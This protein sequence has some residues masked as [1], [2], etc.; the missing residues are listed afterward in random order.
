[1]EIIENHFEEKQQRKSVVSGA[2]KNTY[3]QVM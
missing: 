2:V 1:M 3:A